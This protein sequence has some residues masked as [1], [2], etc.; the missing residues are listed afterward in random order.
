MKL[1]LMSLPEDILTALSQI[2]LISSSCILNYG[3][4]NVFRL[5]KDL[6]GETLTKRI[7]ETDGFLQ[8]PL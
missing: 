8:H 4:K 1:Y 6:R 3:S 5:W 2:L 7:Y